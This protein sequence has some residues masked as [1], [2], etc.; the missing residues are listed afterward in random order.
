[1]YYYC[2]KTH[3]EITDKGFTVT[4]L[5]HGYRINGC[6][7]LYYNQKTI[8]NKITKEYTRFD[9]RHEAKATAYKLAHEI[10]EVEPFKKTSKGNM[11]YQEF[12]HNMITKNH[13]Q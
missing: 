8:F 13:N 4:I 1:M 2:K 3:K 12:K 9:D 7:D 6:I 10:G 11:T 5:K